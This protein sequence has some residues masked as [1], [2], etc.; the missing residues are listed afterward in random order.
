MSSEKAKADAID[1][2]ELSIVPREQWLLRAEMT[3]SRSTLEV[4][5]PADSGCSLSSRG[6]ETLPEAGKPYAENR[7]LRQEAGKSRKQLR[8]TRQLQA[9]LA[10]L[11]DGC[12]PRVPG[13]VRSSILSGV[14]N[15]APLRIEL[16]TRT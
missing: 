2:T 8:M 12:S 9:D 3:C 16:R 15:G 1:A 6:E 10:A 4:R 14:R 7:M 11:G 5:C 13:G